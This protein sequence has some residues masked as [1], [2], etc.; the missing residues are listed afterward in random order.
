MITHP[1]SAR[2]EE[3]FVNCF[4]GESD[5]VDRPLLGN[6][7][8]VVVFTESSSSFEQLIQGICHQSKQENSLIHVIVL[9]VD[10]SVSARFFFNGYEISRCGSGALAATRAVYEIHGVE[11][12]CI[13][14]SCQLLEVGIDE[15][16]F[17]FVKSMNLNYFNVKHLKAWK[18]VVGSK[19]VD[20]FFIGDASDYCA[21]V[22]PDFDSLV[23]SQPKLNLLKLVSR[24]ALILTTPGYGGIDYGIRYFAPQY[25]NN[26]DAATGSANIQIAKYWQD[27]YKK[28][29]VV[30][31]QFSYRGG[32]FK[33]TINSRHQW[34]FGK[35]S[36]SG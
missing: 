29:T 3:F 16:C 12:F 23:R 18:R 30:G 33:V 5:L 6:Q 15:E 31:Q 17:C 24:R 22:L 26:E 14:T 2:V 7:H 10:S 9:V 8:R 28:E 1:D 35:T 25:G 32:L 20:Q 13:K 21:L 11:K 36:I 19:L 27:F 4:V 34:L